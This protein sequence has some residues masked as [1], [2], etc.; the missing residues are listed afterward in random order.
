MA[1][2]LDH[3]IV[4]AHDK[5]KSARFIAHIMGLEY[6][7]LWGHFAPVKVNDTLGLDFDNRENFQANHYAFIVTDE[8]FDAILGRVKDADGLY[9][10]PT[11]VTGRVVSNHRHRLLKLCAV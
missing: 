9:F 4:P 8:D 11:V 3:T 2:Y 6:D 5:E 1:I 7:G 10:E